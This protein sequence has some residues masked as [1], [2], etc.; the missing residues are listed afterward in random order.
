MEKSDNA[1]KVDY[2]IVQRILSGEKDSFRVLQDKYYSIIHTLIKRMIKNE[3]DVNDLTQESFIKAYKALDKF[4]YGYSFSA[5]LYRI[6]S[7][8]C[9]D[10]LRKKRFNEISLNQPLANT[11]D[12]YLE[13][14]DQSYIP[15]IEIQNKE[16]S[17]VLQ[18]A[19]EKLPDN[20]RTIIKLRHEEE[21]DYK[22]IAERLNIPLGTVKA[23]LFR[24]R[25]LLFQAL[26]KH[27]HLFNQ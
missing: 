12:Y 9:I 18:Q 26:K 8:T 27:T 23:H 4:Q 16:K 6:A 1:Y 21:L 13:I 22:E 5:W 19:I 14:E 11:D 20:Y 24:A 15:D 10:F 17:I 3:D 25:K 7:N 2:E